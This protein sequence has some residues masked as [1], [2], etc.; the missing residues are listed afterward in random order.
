MLFSEFVDAQGQ[1]L[2]LDTNVTDADVV[3]EMDTYEMESQQWKKGKRYLNPMV[4]W[5]EKKGA[6]P[7]LYKLALK[8]LAIPS[9]SV[10]SEQ[11]FSGAGRISTK[12]RMSLGKSTIEMLVLLQRSMSREDVLNT[13]A[14]QFKLERRKI[15]VERRNK[16][17]KEAYH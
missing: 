1:D 4:F 6:Y 7:N 11:V 2:P 16:V 5:H 15:E 14:E 3:S 10:L 8:V 13:T 17:R 9:T 12:E